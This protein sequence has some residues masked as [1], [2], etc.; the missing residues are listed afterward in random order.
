MLDRSGELT[1]HNAEMQRSH[2]MKMEKLIVLKESSLK[3]NSVRQRLLQSKKQQ[4]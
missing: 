1:V 4:R 2:Q 3:G